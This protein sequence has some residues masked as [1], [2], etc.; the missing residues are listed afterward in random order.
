MSVRS[1]LAV[2]RRK[3][4][5][6]LYQHT[7]AFTIATPVIS[8]T[9]DDF[10]RSAYLTGGGVLEHFGARGTYYAAAGLMNTE[11]ELGPQFGPNDLDSL[12]GKGH[13]LA[14][15]TFSHISCRSVSNSIFRADVQ[16]GRKAIE[17]IAGVSSENF[18]YPF[19]HVTV[20]AKG[21]LAQGL[22]SSRSIFPGLNGPE[23]DLN[24]LRANRLYGDIGQ[25]RSEEELIRE[26]IRQ[27]SWLIFYTHDVRPKPSAYGCTPA[28]LESA[29]S[30]AVRSGCRI[31][32]VKEV[33][34]ELGV[35]AATPDK[36]AHSAEAL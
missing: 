3:I 1:H 21:V 4:L 23:F 10:P 24:L 30:F 33:L 28:L 31:L 11:N 12:V 8:F 16:K 35:Q 32:T 19:G 14:T 27:R 18:A 22:A 7:M 2:A 20:R 17:E 25:S 5:F 29:V 6:S 15:H 34:T 26:N 13:E 9:F 36:Q